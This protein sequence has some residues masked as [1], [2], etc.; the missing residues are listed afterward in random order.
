MTGNADG[1]KNSGVWAILNAAN[2]LG[3]I[4]KLTN[5]TVN[6]LLNT[7]K[8]QTVGLFMLKIPIG[9][10]WQGEELGDFQ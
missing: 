2:T 10:V 7:V 9:N 4:R 1:V 5:N 6:S 8:V 3:T